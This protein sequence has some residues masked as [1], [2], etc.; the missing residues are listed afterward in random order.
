MQLVLAAFRMQQGQTLL[1]GSWFGVDGR[2]HPVPLPD[3]IDTSA[4]FLYHCCTLGFGQPASMQ[5]VPQAR[6]LA[7]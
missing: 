7:P 3:A 2:H 6:A 5:S 4:F 1:R